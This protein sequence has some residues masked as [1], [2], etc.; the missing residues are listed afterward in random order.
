[1]IGGNRGHR[2]SKTAAS[3]C[4]SRI[5]LQARHQTMSRTLALAALP[6]VL[7]RPGWDFIAARACVFR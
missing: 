6:S 4:W 3:N 7:G 1:V 5:C 2:I